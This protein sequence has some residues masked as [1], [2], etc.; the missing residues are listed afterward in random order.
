MPGEILVKFKE[1]KGIQTLGVEI[2][3]QN[4]LFDNIYRLKLGK[5]ADIFEIIDGFKNN[6]D[7][8]YAEPNYIRH[9]CKTPN[10]TYFNQ[11][12]GLSKIQAPQGWDIEKG[13]SG[14]I[15]AI[16]DTGID[17]N[18]PD[19]K[20]KIVGSISFVNGQSPMD[21][22]GHGTHVSGIAGASTNNSI[23]VSGL[24]WNCNLL[25]VKCLDNKGYGT[26]SDISLAIR[27]AADYPGVKVINMSFGG[28]DVGNTLKDA[29][30]YAYGTKGTLLVAAAGNDGTQEIFYPA[31]YE[32]VMA[33]AA[34]DSNDQ[35]AYFS[36]YGDWVDISA[37][38]VS[39]LSTIPDNSYDY[40]NGTSMASPFVA[41]LAG[42]LFSK[43]STITNKEVFN[44]IQT[45]SD[46]VGIWIN[47]G[48]INVHC[49]LKGENRKPKDFS[50]IQPEGWTS[51]PYPV[52]KW[53]KSEDLDWGDKITYSIILNNETVATKIEETF[54]IPD[55]SRPLSLNTTYS[56][57][58]IA[59]DSRGSTTSLGTSTFT[60][61]SFKVFPNPARFGKTV[62]FRG[63]PL[64]SKETSI[65]IYT[66]AGE[67]VE[68]L[69]ENK[70]GDVLWDTK[71][72]AS[73]VY[74]YIISNPD[75]I[76]AS[77]KI[78][79]IK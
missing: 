1:K 70:G 76:F 64:S 56:W 36:N 2:Q 16:L 11:Q 74:L 37:P 45:R 51:S 26:D 73:G 72:I 6:P 4:E 21:G 42:L 39:I 61:T 58:V 65:S 60:T 78:G 75:K 8:I 24:A 77:G 69:P 23:G 28:S 12:W 18:H 66:L 13:S 32:S 44:E 31:G 57:Q 79:I 35:K 10:D 19:L 71:N 49:A 48:R 30:D 55:F 47:G 15:I 27:Y 43:Y 29:C 33:V 22:H 14:V 40:F 54:W 17:Y 62:I 25:A 5:G 7:V 52:F 3:S 59:V 67:L 41:G 9:I 46:D 63:T 68:R 50:I 20:L 53:S 34:T 38:G